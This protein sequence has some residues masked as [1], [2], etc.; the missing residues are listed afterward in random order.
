LTNQGKWKFLE[1]QK[2]FNR[3]K[4]F[5]ARSLNMKLFVYCAGGFGREIYD[6]AKRETEANNKWDEICFIDDNPNLDNKFYGT[7]LFTFNT[8]LK[9]YD[10]ESFEVSIANGEPTVRKA[11]YDKLKSH[12]IKLAT[13]VDNSAII[14]DTAKMEE[15][16]IITAY[17]SVSCSAMVRSNVAINTKAIV[18]HDVILGEHCVVSSLVNIGGASTIGENSYLGMG[19]QIKEG[20][21]IGKDVIVGMGSV[22][23]NDIPGGVIALGNPARPMRQNVDKRVFKGANKGSF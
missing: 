21:K 23:Y 9:N 5:H 3:E 4:A 10:V 13:V 18:G 2:T 8:V 15:G 11:I 20:T 19:V 1:A 6:T 12:N 22:V 14:S 16:V 7:K 17:C